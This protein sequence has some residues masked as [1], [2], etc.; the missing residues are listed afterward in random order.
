MALGLVERPGRLLHHVLRSLAGSD[1]L[2]DF[3]ARTVSICDVLS[4]VRLDAGAELIMWHGA[5]G[6]RIA[7]PIARLFDDVEAVLL[8]GGVDQTAPPKWSTPV[9]LRSSSLPSHGEM[10][11]VAFAAMTFAQFIGGER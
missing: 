4:E 1:R 10:T 5:D 8:L 3:D 6:S 11:V 7:T 9:V 2:S